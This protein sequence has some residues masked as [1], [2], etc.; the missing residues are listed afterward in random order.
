MTSVSISD[1]SN[2]TN[3]SATVSGNLDKLES[4]NKIIQ[5]GFVWAAHKNPTINDSKN[6]LGEKDAIG[7]FSS[8]LDG[9]SYATLYYIRA[10]V[11]DDNEKIYYSDEIFFTTKTQIDEY[12]FVWATHTNPTINDYKVINNIKTNQVELEFTNNLGTLFIGRTYIKAY[13]KNKFGVSY[14]KEINITFTSKGAIA[15][16]NIKSKKSSEI[17]LKTIDANNIT[18]DEAILRGN[19]TGSLEIEEYGFVRSINTNPN[20]SDAIQLGVSMSG[21]LSSKFS[22]L[23][24]ATSYYYK[25]YVKDKYGIIR[26]GQEKFFTTQTKTIECGFVWATHINPTV[27]DYKVVSPSKGRNFGQY[28]KDLGTMFIGTMYVRSYMMNKFG[29]EYGNELEIT[30]TSSGEIAKSKFLELDC[31]DRFIFNI[32]EP[33]ININ[34]VA[35]KGTIKT[36]KDNIRE[37]GVIWGTD[38]NLTYSNGTVVNL[39]NKVPSKEFNYNIQELSYATL[40]YY[41]LYVKDNQGI[42]HYSREKFFTTGTLIEDYG[43]VWSTAHNPTI[44]DN[45]VHNGETRN[46]VDIA[47]PL[48]V[49]RNGANYVKAFV[50][51]KFGVTYGNELDIYVNSTGKIANLNMNTH[52]GCNPIIISTKYATDITYN[53]ATLN[54]GIDKSINIQKYGFVWSTHTKPTLSDNKIEFNGP[55]LKAFSHTIN[56]LLPTTLYFYKPYI[57][58]IQ[59]NIYYGS[60]KFLETKLGASEYGFVCSVNNNPTVNDIKINL[61]TLGNSGHFSGDIVGLKPETTYHIKAYTI[62][63]NNVIYGNELTFITDKRTFN[64]RYKINGDIKD[65]TAIYYKKDRIWKTGTSMNVKIGGEWKM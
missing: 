46:E 24:Y 49:L 63:T 39:G 57:V 25:I 45:I 23:T 65:I 29:I 61:G 11:K 27:S 34:D 48:P 30:F 36:S 17:M 5:H 64:L 14:G 51:N 18:T 32:N 35:V 12:G 20:Y 31:A 9:L 41:K 19:I 26:Y 52:V 58:D 43:F 59:N 37:Y 4:S 62:V 2:I 33:I 60:E 55:P 6:E 13:C 22:R 7:N 8:S 53:N 44:S 28:I 16:S 10:Y 42:I 47:N 3:N 1:I 40:Y 54:A 50:K 15:N 21:D 56:D 38:N